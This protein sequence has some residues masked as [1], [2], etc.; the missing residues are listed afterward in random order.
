MV[1]KNILSSCNANASC[2]HLLNFRGSKRFV[3]IYSVFRNCCKTST[4]ATNC[5]SCICECSGETTMK[6]E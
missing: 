1:K 6:R 2:N 5:K 4:T 3:A